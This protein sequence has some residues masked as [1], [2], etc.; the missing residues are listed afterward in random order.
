MP[1]PR[2]SGS[3]RIPRAKRKAVVDVATA[4]AVER[5]LEIA[6]G[7]PSVTARSVTNHV[8]RE[9]ARVATVLAA[10]RASEIAP[11]AVENR[12][13]TVRSVTSH[14]RRVIARAATAHAAR[15]ASEIAQHVVRNLSVSVRSATSPAKTVIAHAATGLSVTS[16]EAQNR[17][18]NPAAGPHRASLLLENQVNVANVRVF[19]ARAKAPVAVAAPAAANR[20][21]KARVANLLVA[22]E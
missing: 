18:A 11:H 2:A 8:K 10:R 4:R 7:N 20:A 15:R 14:V 3:V 9:I 6:A 16:Q 21:A 19:Q 22:G 13:A 12:L 1:I 5:A 17:V